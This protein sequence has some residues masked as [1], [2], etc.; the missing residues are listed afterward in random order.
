MSVDYGRGGRPA[1]RGLDLEVPAGTRLG[2]VGP[3]GSGKS[4][5]ASLLLRLQDPDAGRVLLDGRDA[6]DYTLASLRGQQAIV[7]QESGLFAGTA[8]VNVHS[9]TFPRGEIR[10]FPQFVGIPEPSSVVLLAAALGG[11]GLMR[12][13]KLTSAR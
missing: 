11:L 12:R 6:R 4:T 10:G 9:T 2:V 13:R 8:Y 7:L 1:L 5:L 3:S